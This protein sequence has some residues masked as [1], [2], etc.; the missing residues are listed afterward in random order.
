M[1]R[2]FSDTR[3][4]VWLAGAVGLAVVC[5]CLALPAEV[6]ERSEQASKSSAARS[7]GAAAPARAIPKRS[8]KRLFSGH[9]VDVY[10]AL[11]R[12]GLAVAV[13]MK[14]QA[15][16]ETVGGELIPIA[17]DWRGRAFF[18]DERLRD[19]KVQLVGFRRPGLPY[20]F[21]LTV[22]VFDKQ[23][24]RLE[25]DYWCDTCAIPQY[26]LEPCSCCQ[27]PVQLR[28]RPAELPD[29]LRPKRGAAPVRRSSAP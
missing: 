14:G 7:D 26:D 16:L 24:R 9:V 15:A 21:V 6:V 18:Q 2:M 28:L 19:R 25:V 22:Y 23:G 4:A 17:A 8:P 11:K 5:W 13:E 10:Q 29:E 1:R 12:R 3:S 27:G 20:L